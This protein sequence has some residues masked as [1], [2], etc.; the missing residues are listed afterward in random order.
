MC[1][2][3]AMAL[4]GL[5]AILLVG[6][7]GNVLPVP[8]R[9][10]LPAKREA[11]PADIET[12]EKLGVYLGGEEETKA[13][14]MAEVVDAT[15]LLLGILP[16]LNVPAYCYIRDQDAA[17]MRQQQDAVELV[18]FDPT[19]VT[20]AERIDETGRGHI[21]TDE[22]GYRVLCIQRALFLLDGEMAGHVLVQDEEGTWGC[23]AIE[24]GE[25]IDTRWVEAV[26]QS[27][28]G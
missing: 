22:R 4:V 18:F 26:K 14:R 23:W 12:V 25:G 15:R 3:L 7:C 17:Q 5:S 27:I 1:C 16:Q 11:L 8:R 24:T 19:E 9:R 28:R 2:R 6:G 13:P 21:L 10:I 20:I